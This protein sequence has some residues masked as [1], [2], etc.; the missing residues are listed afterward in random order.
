MRTSVRILSL[1]FLAALPVI[2]AEII[3][4]RTSELPWAVVN[5]GYRSLIE[6]GLDARCPDG[7]V[8][9]S[10]HE[11]SLPRGL[12]IRGGYILGTP[13]EIGRFPFSVRAVNRC[14]SAVKA[15]EL[16][17][18]GKP[19]LRVFPEE[20]TCEYRAGEPGPA[21]LNVRVS[22]SWPDLQ[23]SMRI[24]AP[25][26]TGKVRAGA[27]PATGS[28]LASDS[29][30]LEIDP[31]NLAPGTYRTSVRFSTWLGANA[32]SVA[33]TLKVVAAE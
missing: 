28:G 21:P 25:W 31:K 11:G 22:G 23:Y 27:T 17:V 14:S 16:I 4:V 5:A 30:S 9:V 19:I 32:P 1:C 10:L 15:L 13:K 2:R 26:L 12:E 18:T 6:T 33:V 20:L 7:D 29:V 24:D 3:D 8:E